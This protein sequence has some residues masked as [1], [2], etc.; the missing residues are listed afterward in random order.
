MTLDTRPSLVEE[1]R[2]NMASALDTYSRR[3]LAV[4]E[5]E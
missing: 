3:R 5:N 4:L 2:Q 1:V